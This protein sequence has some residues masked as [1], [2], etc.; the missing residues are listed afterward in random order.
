ML[1]Y[2]TVLIFA[3]IAQLVST[4]FVIFRYREE[5]YDKT[6]K[7]FAFGFICN[8]LGNILFLTR[9]VAPDWVSINLANLLIALASLLLLFAVCSVFKKKISKR[10]W[11]FLLLLKAAGFIYFTQ[12]N[13]HTG[14]RI[15]ILGVFSIAALIS[16]VIYPFQEIRKMPRTIRLLFPLQMILISLVFF[17]RILLSIEYYTQMKITEDWVPGMAIT[18]IFLA[19]L[20]FSIALTT[21]LILEAKAKI[22]AEETASQLGTVLDERDKI[23]MLVAHELQ[24]P[25]TASLLAFRNNGE[26]PENKLREAETEIKNLQNLVSELLAWARLRVEGDN[27]IGKI[28]LEAQ[29]REI[30][31]LYKRDLNL[32]KLQFDLHFPQESLLVTENSQIYRLALRAIMGNIVKYAEQGSFVYFSV[33]V[34]SDLMK[35]I[36]RNK[37]AQN[38]DVRISNRIGLALLKGELSQIG[39]SLETEKSGGWFSVTIHLPL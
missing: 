4:I 23:Y 30:L 19:V 20:A 8:L 33:E 16:S 32:N 13:Y 3:T 17:V 25:L 22:K 11:V 28:Y 5:K 29:F 21:V 10:I 37:I 1:H 39:G 12:I 6:L 34:K 2:P 26:N 24:S 9:N 36:C 7:I 18:R 27:K 14:A 38:S 35:I 31:Y 15:I